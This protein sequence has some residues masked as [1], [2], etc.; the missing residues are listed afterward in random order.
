MA[1]EKNKAGRGRIVLMM[2]LTFGPALLLVLF[3]LN[4]CENKFVELPV[5]GELPDYSYQDS[6]GVT[7]TSKEMEDKIVFVS[8]IQPSCP[9]DCAIDLWQYQIKVYKNLKLNQKKMGHVKMIS[10]VTDTNEV[11]I[12]D[13][14]LV[15]DILTDYLDKYAKEEGAGFDP[16]IWKIV[17]AD[18][19]DFYGIDHEG[20]NLYDEKGDQYYRGSLYQELILLVDKENKLRIARSGKQEGYIREIFQHMALL[21]KQYAIENKKE[22]ETD[23]S[24]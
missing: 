20:K 11:T 7:H 23:A 1:K 3:S 19:K 5:Y 8:T 6:K 9:G 17:K 14:K 4:R 13:V 24:H 2:C 10:I 12:E 21:Q 18:P 16:N 22:N 15:E